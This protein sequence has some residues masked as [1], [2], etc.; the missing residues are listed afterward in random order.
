MEKTLV[1]HEKYQEAY[2][3]RLMQY[4]R[5]G[6]AARLLEPFIAE[7]A[8]MGEYYLRVNTSVLPD[9]L[10]SGTI[11]SMMETH[12]GTTNGGEE[13]RREVVEKLFGCDTSQLEP[14]D[15]PKFGFL[16]QANPVRD[17]TLNLNMS[18]QYGNASI[19]LR[20]DRLCHRTTI[21]VG[22]SVNMGTF[23]ALV[24]ARVDR[25]KATCIV[26]LEHGGKCLFTPPQPTLVYFYLAS[27]VQEKKL[28]LD[29][30][31]EL[32]NIVQQFPVPMD[33][34]ELQYHGILSL[35][36]DVERID[37]LP[38]SAAEIESLNR[39]KPQFEALGIPLNVV[40]L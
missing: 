33:F 16:S 24:P 2:Y 10:A 18:Y 15:Y 8:C 37:V 28:T 22:N 38:E 30:F 1:N 26:G 29:N 34:F 39:L 3:Q 4:P 21:S 25:V 23:N 9:I 36:D 12:H 13:T 7:V 11:K 17:L 31:A 14:A 35:R 6:L 19:R 40:T 27:L 20:K 32:D 5:F